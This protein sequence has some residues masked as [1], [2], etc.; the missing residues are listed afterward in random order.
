M[1]GGERLEGRFKDDLASNS[2]RRRRLATLANRCTLKFFLEI[3]SEKK[4][5]GGVG[6]TLASR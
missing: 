3:K 1:E 5:K 2:S 4:K 6:G